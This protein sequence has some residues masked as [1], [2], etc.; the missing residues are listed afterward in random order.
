[1]KDELNANAARQAQ[2]EAELAATEEPP[3]VLHPEMARIYRERV[4]GLLRPSGSQTAD[5]RRPRRYAALWTPS[6]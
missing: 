5:L 2:L 4:S 3:P 6:C 1:V